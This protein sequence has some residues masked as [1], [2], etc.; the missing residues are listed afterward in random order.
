[1]SKTYHMCISVTG[2]LANWS[3]KRLRGVFQHD[4]GRP[5]TGHD[6]KLF[7]L[8]EL[9]KGHRVIPCGKPCEGFDY[10]GDGCPGHE[11][12]HEGAPV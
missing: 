5:M 3:E 12:D 1:M 10:A 6:A 9:A 2:V 8:E 4:D 11:V 7:L